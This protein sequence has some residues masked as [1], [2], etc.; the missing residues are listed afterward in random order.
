ML[1]ALLQEEEV[2]PA[3]LSQ[4]ALGKLRAKREQFEQA[5]TGQIKPHHRL[6][7]REH[8]AHIDSVDAATRRL[9]QEI[10]E[11]MRP[12]EHWLQRLE[13]IVG[14]KRRLAEV[15]LAESGTDMRRFPSARHLAR[16]RGHVSR[17]RRERR[18]TPQ[19][20]DTQRP[21]VAANGSGRGCSWGRPEFGDLS[22][23]AIPPSGRPSR[24]QEGHGRLRSDDL[25]DHLACLERR[26]RL[27]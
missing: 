18:Q 1:E 12:W 7:I 22:V 16:L 14:I 24:G 3:E 8:L 21:S 27:L 9:S 4:L 11:R 2:D 6:L 20:Q 13:T 25:G 15:I 17:Q 26:H 10:A 5:L 23:G 19:W